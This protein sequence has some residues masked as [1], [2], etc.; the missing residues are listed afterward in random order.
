MAKTSGRVCWEWAFVAITAF[1]GWSFSAIHLALQSLS[2]AAFNTWRFAIAAL[3]LLPIWLLRRHT[4]SRHDLVGGGLAGLALF[5]AFLFQ[6]KGLSY[7]TASN[8]S[9]ITGLAVIITPLLARWWLRI[10]L[11]WQQLAGAL[12][13]AIGLAMLTLSDMQLRLGDALVLACAFFFAVH[14]ILLSRAS[15]L[16][17]TLNITLVQLLVVAG[18]SAT[19]AGLGHALALPNLP[20]LLH[21]V[22]PIALLGTALGFF[23]QTRAQVLS[24]PNKIALIIVMEPV[25]GGVFGYLLAGDRLT[26]FNCCGALLIVLAMLLTEW[27]FGRRRCDAVV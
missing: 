27:Q 9:F 4:L 23:V 2:D 7:T 25:F 26:L 3:C 14:V 8:A 10:T 1:W 22:L 16:A 18:L 5:A 20:T 6:T 17:D 24:S 11:S 21:S 19:Q 13:A 12:L 15:K